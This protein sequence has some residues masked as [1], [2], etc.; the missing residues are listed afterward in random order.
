MI[1]KSPKAAAM[2]EIANRML[3]P[4]RINRSETT[5]ADNGLIKPEGIG[6]FCV[7]SIKASCFHSCTSFK[8]LAPEAR[9]NTPKVRYNS[10][11]SNLA[12]QTI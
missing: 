6:R 8:A 1:L 4:V 10:V 9:A 11:K 5:N 2:G 12:E 7:L 3:E